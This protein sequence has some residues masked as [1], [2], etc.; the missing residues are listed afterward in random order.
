MTPSEK[1][2]AAG[3]KSLAELSRITGRSVRTLEYW[4]NN[5]PGFFKIVLR[6]A[7][8]YNAEYGKRQKRPENG[9]I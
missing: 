6:G 8:A 3:L 5:T 2:K 4:S 7:V 9:S 1:C